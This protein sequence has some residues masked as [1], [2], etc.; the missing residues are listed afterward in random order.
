M[1]EI[2]MD[3]WCEL[4]SERAV[5]ARKAHICSECRRA[6]DP[7]ET[8]V[9]HFSKFEGDVSYGKIC[10][11][12]ESDRDQFR[13]AHNGA[14][15]APPAFD[16]CLEQCIAEGDEESDRVWAPM[17]ARLRDRRKAADSAAGRPH[18]D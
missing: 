13:T 16:E 1:C 14:M 9:V 12:C 8:Y 3:S 17:L 2:D 6:I 15:Y 11:T 7:G 4:W 18:A 5:R 10:G